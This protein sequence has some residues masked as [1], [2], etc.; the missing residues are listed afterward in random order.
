MGQERCAMDITQ[1]PET[2]PPAITISRETAVAC[3]TSD[4]ENYGSGGPVALTWQ[5]ALVGKGPTPIA[6]ETWDQGPPSHTTL[7]DESRWP[8]TNRWQGHVSWGEFQ[9]ARFL[10][11]WLTAA[12]GEEV[13]PRFRPQDVAPEPTATEQGS[14]TVTMTEIHPGECLRPFR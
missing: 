12:D 6:L 9:H 3:M 5:W 4:L 1:I 14:I 7:L 11:W 2:L 13:P 8:Y 10:L